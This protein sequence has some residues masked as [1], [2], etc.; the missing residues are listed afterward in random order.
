MTYAIMLVSFTFN[1]FILCYIGEVLSSQ[2]GYVND[3]SMSA[4]TIIIN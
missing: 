3:R 2:V 1:I 4:I